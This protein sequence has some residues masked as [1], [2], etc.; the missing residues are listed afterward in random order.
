MIRNE[1]CVYDKATQIIDYIHDLAQ[2][3][4]FSDYGNNL[5]DQ[6][7]YLI[8]KNLYSL[9]LQVNMTENQIRVQS[10]KEEEQFAEQPDA[11]KLQEFKERLEKEK[12]LK[13][14]LGITEL[15]IENIVTNGSKGK[16]STA[17]MTLLKN[18]G[19]QT[20]GF[21]AATI[22]VDERADGIQKLTGKQ[23]AQISNEISKTGSTQ[24][25]LMLKSLPSIFPEKMLNIDKLKNED[26]SL[27]GIVIIFTN[28][29]KILSGKADHISSQYAKLIGVPV[30]VNP[31]SEQ[32]R[33]TVFSLNQ[34]GNN[35][36][37]TFF[38]DS[39]VAPQSSSA[40]YNKL[41]KNAAGEVFDA[42]FRPYTP[43]DSLKPSGRAEQM[44]SF[45]LNESKR[46]KSLAE[47]FNPVMRMETTKMIANMFSNGL[48]GSIA[49]EIKRIESQF[50]EVKNSKDLIQNVLSHPDWDND[51]LY[52]LEDKNTAKKTF[53]QKYPPKL[54][55]DSIRN[56]FAAWLRMSHEQKVSKLREKSAFKNANDKVI[57]R[58]IQE[59]DNIYKLALIKDDEQGIDNFAALCEEASIFISRKEGFRLAFD[60]RNVKFDEIDDYTYDEDEYGVVQV[61]KIN[62]AASQEDQPKDGWMVKF[63]ETSSFDSLSKIVRKL[64]D[65]MPLLD[66][67][68]KKKYFAGMPQFLDSNYVHALLIDKLHNIYDDE[69]VLPTL[70]R[71]LPQYPWLKSLIDQLDFDNLQQRPNESDQAFAERKKQSMLLF[72][73]FV[74]DMNKYFTPFWI[75]KRS[76]RGN[77]EIWET[78]P[79]N[80]PEG[81]NYLFDSWRNSYEGGEQLT[82]SSVKS[83]Y[84]SD[85]DL[86][87]SIAKDNE[88][89]LT[90]LKNLFTV[91]QRQKDNVGL[92]DD[93]D[94]LIQYMRSVGINTQKSIL[95]VVLDS[96][97]NVNTIFEQLNII[98][99][100]IQKLDD[101]VLQTTDLLNNFGGAYQ[102]IAELIND[103]DENAVESSVRQG[104]K[105]YYSHTVPSYLGNFMKKIQNLQPNKEIPDEWIKEYNNMSQEFKDIFGQP[106]DYYH[107]FL[108]HE[109]GRYDWFFHLTKNKDGKVVS[110]RWMH[111][112]IKDLYDSDQRAFE[113]IKH[114]VLL[115][116]D[117]KEYEKWDPLSHA[118]LLFNEY[119]SEKVEPNKQAYGY[120]HV[121]TLADANSAEFIRFKK[122][123][124]GHVKKPNMDGYYTYQELIK[125]RIH[126]VVLQEYNRIQLVK[127][128]KEA[129]DSG[130]LDKRNK[131]LHF[132]EK[133]LQFNF[134]PQLNNY[135]IEENGKKIKFLDKLEELVKQDLSAD[136]IYALI[137]TAIDDIMEIGFEQAMSEWDNIKLFDL[138][139][140]RYSDNLKIKDSNMAKNLDTAIQK[141]NDNNIVLDEYG[142]SAIRILNSLIQQNMIMANREQYKSLM[143]NDRVLRDLIDSFERSV[144]DDKNQL[145]I[146][147][148]VYDQISRFLNARDEIRETMREYYWNTV[149]AESQIIEMFTT[150]LAYYKNPEDFVKRIKEIHAPNSNLNTNAKY[151]SSVKPDADINVGKQYESVIYINDE[152]MPSLVHKEL[153]EA[154]NNLKQK[155][156]IDDI[157]IDFILSNY[158]NIKLTDGQAFRSFSSYRRIRIMAGDWT[159]QQEQAY[160]NIKE[161]KF[162]MQ[163][164]MTVYQT[165]KPYMF[166]QQ[167]TLS[168]FEENSLL[169]LPIQHKNS[170]FML[171]AMFDLVSNELGKNSKIKALNR[172][173]EESGIEVVQFAS[174][175]KIGLQGAIDFDDNTIEKQNLYNEDKM[176]EYLRNQC[177]KDGNYKT[178]NP[179]VVHQVSYKDW[180][181]QQA[182]PEHL[183]DHVQIFGTQIRKLIRQDMEDN[184]EIQFNGQTLTKKQWLYLYDALNTENILSAFEKLSPEFRDINKVHD[185][186]IN[187]MKG[188]QRYTIDDQESIRV[189]NGQFVLPICDPAKANKIQAL[190]NS[191]LRKRV[192]N[193]RINGGTAIQVTAYGGSDQLQIRWKTAD[194][195]FIFNEAEFNGDE[196]VQKSQRGLLREMR[197][198]Y[199]SFEEYKR[200]NKA[201]SI[202]YVE[203]FMPATSYDMLSKAIG[204]GRMMDINNIPEDMRRVV[205]YRIPTENKYSMLPLYIKGFMPQ[206]NGSTIMLPNDWVN[207]SGSDFDVDKLYMMLQTAKDKELRR[208]VYEFIDEPANKRIRGKLDFQSETSMTN[209]EF[210]KIISQLKYMSKA[211]RDNMLIDMMFDM[212]SNSASLQAQM[213]PGNYNQLTH[214][215]EI[216]DV[217]DNVP[218]DR[219]VDMLKQET[220]KDVQ[221]I[222]NNLY[223]ILESIDHKKIKEI[224]DKYKKFNNLLSPISQLYFHNQNMAGL[225]LVGIYANGTS[226]HALMQELGL[227]IDDSNQNS[228]VIN[229]KKAKFFDERRD[230]YGNLISANLAQPQAA[231]VDNIKDPVLA[232]LNQNTFTANIMPTLLR[233]GYSLQDVNYFLKQPI[234]VEITNSFL[235]GDGDIETI[236]NNIEFQYAQEDARFKP[237]QSQSHENEKNFSR[238]FL[239]K[240]M[241]LSKNSRINQDIN[242]FT[243]D[244]NNDDII[245]YYS[246]QLDVLR[247][248]RKIYKVAQAMTSL[249]SATRSDTQ[250]GSAGPLISDTEAKINKWQ[251]ILENDVFPITIQNGTIDELQKVNM[252]EDFNKTNNND[253]IRFDMYNSKIPFLQAFYTFGLEGSRFLFKDYFPQL[254]LPFRQIVRQMSELSKYSL[255][256][257]T[258][259]DIYNA[260][261]AYAATSRN[262]WG[263]S[264]DSTARQKRLFF[265]GQFPQEL[266][267]LSNAKGADGKSLH[268]D[269]V[270]NEFLKRLKVTFVDKQK[271]RIDG[272]LSHKGMMKISFRN[273]GQLTAY[274]KEKYMREWE[275]MLYSDDPIV[276]RVAVNLFR[277]S[278]YRHGFKFGPTSF[279]HLCPT[280]VKI[281]CPE[282]VQLLRDLTDPKWIRNNF[283]DSEHVANIN[284]ILL[285][286]Q[287][288]IDVKK[289]QL[290]AGNFAD[291]YIRNNIDNFKFVVQNIKPSIKQGEVRSR[292]LSSINFF[293]KDKRIKDIVHFT[294]TDDRLV[295]NQD[296][297]LIKQRVID[298]LTKQMSY[299]LMPYFSVKLNGEQVY[300]KADA[301]T[302][303]YDVTY[304]RVF[305]LGYPNNFIEYDQ[306]QSPDTMTS[307]FWFQNREGRAEWKR[308]RANDVQQQTQDTILPNEPN[309]YEQIMNSQWNSDDIPVSSPIV[310]QAYETKSG[311][312]IVNGLMSATE[313][314]EAE[315]EF[316]VGGPVEE[317]WVV[318]EQENNLIPK[319]KGNMVFSYGNNKRNDVNSKTTFDAII[320]GERT[321]TT[322]FESDGHIDYWK[323]L[324]V[325]DIV[326]FSNGKGKSILVRITKPLHKL[327]GSGK[328]AEIWSKLEGWSIDYFNNKVRP[329]IQEA[330]QMEYEFIQE[331][332]TQQQPTTTTFDNLNPNQEYKNKENIC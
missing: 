259:N 247:M 200:N 177:F 290:Y 144:R 302:M 41:I 28:N 174:C 81:T 191:I 20:S 56:N 300:Y 145:V 253:Y 285:F 26:K 188:N 216:F 171:A 154:L 104:R 193:Q 65:Q 74:H 242:Q 120:Y 35:H 164:F 250:G 24:S 175:V 301:N 232:R 130:K 217:L 279:M 331:I 308:R 61:E 287:D 52:A 317:D 29:K 297:R 304:H 283:V 195:D 231:S 207:I 118:I 258:L 71:N 107:Y 223:D 10:G 123:V 121:T 208:D 183:I 222:T 30:L 9:Y 141:I 197:N 190:V 330:W 185:L 257:T 284:S 148:K 103:F 218:Y 280:A 14:S 153:K 269:L 274:Q 295:T 198:K 227:M 236:M 215:A 140:S 211:Q 128:R 124:N 25:K 209:D 70:R 266:A 139:I 159:D 225:T 194:G 243:V 172:F 323:N 43:T 235:R 125:Q 288:D 133:G 88:E 212:L 62:D 254:Q 282:Y 246:N 40:A 221:E 37:D 82:D 8:I 27:N 36:I 324:K 69:D 72:S 95:D 332:N 187:E 19:L 277:Y 176:V 169:K 32:I 3:F 179:I 105:Q 160:W 114:K 106:Q 281:A 321:A 214:D 17:I 94:N 291:Q 305:P 110:G 307:I 97:K 237:L 66:K 117:G 312:K 12:T 271:I 46:H 113:E 163:D 149:F 244:D 313:I 122:F 260:I 157:S 116:F 294:I 168:G 230:F 192:T 115:S 320:N 167:A 201:E 83:V 119:N 13:E 248:F 147:S 146:D 111:D 142:Q 80:K 86:V 310:E 112:W 203:C 99:S 38:I 101:D 162:N 48:E 2:N 11:A 22:D 325:G 50:I 134:F 204:D 89:K 178:E 270:N 129:F 34:Q 249:V 68:G 59:R 138:D 238:N 261:F 272:D 16:A 189:E 102:K 181:I 109:F 151:L 306:N 315:G 91:H 311:I 33:S 170:E 173:M 47:Y 150:D 58:I 87:K 165:Q 23:E 54:I 93:L 64:I 220:G 73:A 85:G 224:S 135:I 49:K 322:R 78:I 57:E 136:Q 156:L 98:F 286:G 127:K 252:L 202:A 182:T 45:D 210:E 75:Q 240:Q 229:G 303:M 276:R 213:T 108:F 299:E 273:V 131:I 196:K 31:S 278:Y 21:A 264:D 180:G 96:L 92:Q 251:D 245:Y 316:E 318:G 265:I 205:G 314:A 18:L 7:K 166:T 1:V 262:F 5:T 55:F 219:L 84:N 53:L 289:G 44:F 90:Q 327:V 152:E 267:K 268:P 137:D 132:D 143:Y 329:R 15:G 292:N 67:E 241:L 39:D 126:D 296:N 158:E 328:T 228:I 226:H 239:A 319:A 186:L 79:V 51:Y 60:D 206:Q 275:Q 199:N 42:V 326:E 63:R 155:G 77:Q 234:I 100:G 293:T 76:M 256:S 263:D 233:L 298:P 309:Y 255:D 6:Q 184:A 161:N 4:N